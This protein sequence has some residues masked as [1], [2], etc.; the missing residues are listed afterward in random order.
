MQRKKRFV[1]CVAE[2]QLVAHRHGKGHADADVTRG[3]TN[4]GSIVHQAVRPYRRIDHQNRTNSCACES[5]KGNGGTQVGID[6][7][8]RIECGTPE[9]KHLIAS[10][11]RNVVD[12]AAV[13]VR[14]CERRQRDQTLSRT[15]GGDITSRFYPSNATIR[16]ADGRATHARVAAGRRKQSAHM[17]VRN[18]IQPRIHL[19]DPF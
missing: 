18:L 19:C 12:A 1:V 16:Y 5:P 7:R 2:C 9:F 15:G 11:H 13:I 17:D 8:H 4:S 6:W 10:P 14:V 3:P